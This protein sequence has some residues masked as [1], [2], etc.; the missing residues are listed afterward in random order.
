MLSGETV[1]ALVGALV[2]TVAG[3]G[4]S[5]AL[6]EWRRC[7]R[8]NEVVGAVRSS[9]RENVVALKA[10]VEQ[11]QL[12]SPDLQVLDSIG[13]AKFDLLPVATCELIDRARGRLAAVGEKVRLQHAVVSQGGVGNLSQGLA[14]EAK[15]LA[16]EAIEACEAAGASLPK[17]P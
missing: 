8:R 1:A 15:R 4:A 13:V 16:S 7:G 3:A 6:D 9:L 12:T 2:G 11:S 14:N 17:V 5:V 10:L